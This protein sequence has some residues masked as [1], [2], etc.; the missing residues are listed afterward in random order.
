M[1]SKKH[2]KTNKHF[3]FLIWRV[4][5]ACIITKK[6][7]TTGNTK[8]CS[9]YR[10]IVQV[11][12]SPIYIWDHYNGLWYN[13]STYYTMELY[14]NRLSTE[15]KAIKWLTM[16]FLLYVFSLLLS[17]FRYL[18][19]DVTAMLLTICTS[20]VEREPWTLKHSIWTYEWHWHGIWQKRK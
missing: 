11:Y 2:T 1:K 6:A 17:S 9:S 20:N 10:S 19:C 8:K 16:N 14:N 5:I 12:M 3:I 15:E 7:K 18:S 13:H 4:A